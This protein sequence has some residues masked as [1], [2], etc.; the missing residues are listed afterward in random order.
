METTCFW[1]SCWA[2]CKRTRWTTQ[3]IRS[4]KEAVLE[5]LRTWTHST[6]AAPWNHQSSAGKIEVEGVEGRR[7]RGRLRKEMKGNEQRN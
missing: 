3:T 4:P 1:P 5:P 6:R 2:V 7:N